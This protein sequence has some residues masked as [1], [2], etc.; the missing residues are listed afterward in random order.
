[1]IPYERHELILKTLREQGLVK[2]DELQSVLAGV[3][4]STLRR[5]LKE[6]ERR[7][8]IEYLAG[9][10]VKL[11]ET[12]REVEISVKETMHADEKERIGARA[13][14][15]VEDG[16]TIYVDSGSTCAAMLKRLLD[17]PVTIYTTNASACMQPVGAAAKIVMIGGTFNPVTSSFAGPL[18]EATLS[19]LYFEKAFLGVNSLDDERGVMSP[20]FSEA[21]KKRIVRAN[22][23][24]VYVL[25]DSSK[26]HGFSNVKVFGL[27]GLTVIS[28]KG[29]AKIGEHARILVA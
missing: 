11:H 3:S 1:M 22:S 19:D 21:A 10:A 20:G 14:A 17:R 28:E 25:C 2:I 8:N 4:L 15:E 13:A 26:F 24:S 16:E 9:G 27:D 12:A 23:N 7:G 18:T 5:D 29:D 6:L